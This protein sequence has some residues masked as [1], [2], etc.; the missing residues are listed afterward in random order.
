MKIITRISVVVEKANGETTT[1]ARDHVKQSG[2]NPGFHR[3]EVTIAIA[4]AAG[5]FI[6][7]HQLGSDE[8]L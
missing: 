2:D 1:M 4:E 6:Q 8:G 5:A 7:A 3:R